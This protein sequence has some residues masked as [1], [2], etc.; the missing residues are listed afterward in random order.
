M[1]APLEK[2]GQGRGIKC[3]CEV[4][5]G[6]KIKKGIGRERGSEGNPLSARG[7]GRCGA[8]VCVVRIRPTN[9]AWW[10][11]KRNTV[12]RNLPYEAWTIAVNSRY[13]SVTPHH[14][15]HQVTISVFYTTSKRNP[16]QCE[17][18]SLLQQRVQYIP[19][20]AESGNVYL[21]TCIKLRM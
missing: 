12:E 4:R 5:G 16:D 1:T 20:W 8:C 3:S 11:L 18:Q 9:G 19:R 17:L 7:Q 10:N 15:S 6:A 21:L 14:V 13:R 2:G